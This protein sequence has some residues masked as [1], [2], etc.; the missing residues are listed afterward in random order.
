MSNEGKAEVIIGGVV[1]CPELC[2]MIRQAQMNID[3]NSYKDLRGPD[4]TTVRGW[5]KES[6]LMLV[7]KLH[8]DISDLVENVNHISNPIGGEEQNKPTPEII[9]KEAGDIMG[10]AMQ[11]ADVCGC[12]EEC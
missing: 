4:G 1:I 10:R 9:R 7:H 2:V 3:N 5:K 8:R 11:I 6:D 12:I